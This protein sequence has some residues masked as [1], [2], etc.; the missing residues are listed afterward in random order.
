MKKLLLCLLIIYSFNTN[1][2]LPCNDYL[3]LNFTDTWCLSHLTI[4]T[5][6][7]P[8]NIWQIGI[9]QKSFVNPTLGHSIITD[10]MLP[11]P[12]NDTSSFIVR[13]IAG[14]GDYYGLKM[15]NAMYK[16]ETDSL[17]DY[18]TIEFSPDNGLNWYD[19][20]NDTAVS[21]AVTWYI[22][23]V[24]TGISGP[25][26]YYDAILS[27]LASFFN[28][29]IGDTLAFRFTFIS[30]SVYDN[31]GGLVF[32]DIF[33]SEFVEGISETRYKPIKSIIYPNPSANDF[34]IEFTNPN[35]VEFELAVYDIKSKLIFKRENITSNTIHIEGKT[36]SAGTYIYKITNETNKERTWGKFV[37]L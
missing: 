26:K 24:L 5:V 27:D 23:P 21:P 6:N 1:A 33:I 3:N 22:K 14:Y 16:T 25:W 8:D 28:F 9:P 7:K 20:L 13:Y 15:F 32:D 18:G 4:D 35:E 36:L 31:M 17:N 37:K 34:T 29:Q 2:Q 11:Y 30:D 12:V 10:T 19:I